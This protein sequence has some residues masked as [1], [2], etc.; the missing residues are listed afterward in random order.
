[1]IPK[2]RPWRVKLRKG[3]K[4]VVDFVVDAPTKYLA[5]LAARDEIM[6]KRYWKLDYTTITYFPIPQYKRS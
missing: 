4:P 2:V 3:N 1:M 5:Q 6:I